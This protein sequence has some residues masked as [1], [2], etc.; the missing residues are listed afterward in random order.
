MSMSGLPKL[1]V[2]PIWDTSRLLV[3]DDT[4]T[5]DYKKGHCNLSL[6]GFTGVDCSVVADLPPIVGQLVSEPTCNMRD[7]VCNSVGMIAENF[8]LLT[9]IICKLVRIRP[10]AQ[11]RIFGL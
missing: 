8:D 6:L 9:P 4:T 5:N 1:E 10:K 3:A 7:S 2:F 11:Q